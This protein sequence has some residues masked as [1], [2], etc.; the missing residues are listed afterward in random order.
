MRVQ[1]SEAGFSIV[2]V[3]VAMTIFSVG[4]LSIFQVTDS[5]FKVATGTTHRARATALA[6]NSSSARPP[7]QR[8]S[9][10]TSTPAQITYRVK[11]GD[12][13][14]AIAARHDV[15]VADIKRWN[16]LRS[17]ALKIGARLTIH[18]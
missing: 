2:E 9:R 6:A 16:K 1:R 4:I 14:S 3:V 11:K 10:T 5:S 17:N 13:L 15:T 18:R 12:T 8:A 7:V